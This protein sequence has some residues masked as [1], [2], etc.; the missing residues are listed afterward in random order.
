HLA[1]MGTISFPFAYWSGAWHWATIP[2]PPLPPELA[3]LGG[4]LG[5]AVLGLIAGSVAIRRQGI[6]F[7]MITLALA[8]MMYF[9]ALQAKFTGGED[10]IPGVARGM[11]FGF[12]ELKDQGPTDATTPAMLRDG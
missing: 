7:A 5:G 10:G 1:K 8:Q 2:L 6:Y 12:T 4:T 9:F 3:I 11:R